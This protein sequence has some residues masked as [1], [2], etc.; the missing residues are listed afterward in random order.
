MQM[1]Y[2]D[3]STR[4]FTD[5]PKYVKQS[6]FIEDMMTATFQQIKKIMWFA[7]AK[8]TDIPWNDTFTVVPVVSP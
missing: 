7:S 6:R 1:W 3:A 5:K 8:M 4:M 2:A